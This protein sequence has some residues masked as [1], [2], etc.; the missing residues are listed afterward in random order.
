MQRAVMTETGP[1]S[2][3][4]LADIV[5]AVDKHFRVRVA[6]IYILIIKFES[7]SAFCILNCRNHFTRNLLAEHLFI[8]L[9][10]NSL[11]SSHV[12]AD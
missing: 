11:T 1:I 6:N 7:N 9:E 5:Y 4:S 3:E 12:H 2:A 10:R 8:S